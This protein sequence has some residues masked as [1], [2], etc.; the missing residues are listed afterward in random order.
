VISRSAARAF[1]L[2]NAPE[3][4]AAPTMPRQR[5]VYAMRDAYR[6]ALDEVK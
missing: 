1:A 5:A 6:S 4:S 3:S 2:N